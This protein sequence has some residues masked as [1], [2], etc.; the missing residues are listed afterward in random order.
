MPSKGQKAKRLKGKTSLPLCPFT[1][2]P[3]HFFT[4]VM[5]LVVFLCHNFGES[6]DYNKYVVLI[7]LLMGIETMPSKILK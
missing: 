4:A 2:S 6:P 7:A 3:F 1:Y 5:P